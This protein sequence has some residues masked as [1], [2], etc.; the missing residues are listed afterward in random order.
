MKDKWDKRGYL[1]NIHPIEGEGQTGFKFRIY[2]PDPETGEMRQVTRQ[3]GHWTYDDAEKEYLMMEYMGANYFRKEKKK[4]RLTPTRRD[5]EGQKLRTLDDVFQLY[6]EA[7]KGEIRASYS[8][9]MRINYN[10]HIKKSFQYLYMQ[11]INQIVVNNWKHELNDKN[12]KNSASRKLKIHTKN[13]IIAI[14]RS[15]WSFALE[16][17]YTTTPLNITRIKERK[18]KDEI[19]VR[20]YWDS[21]DWYKFIESIPPEKGRE[22]ALFILC[23]ATGGRISEIRCSKEASFNFRTNEITIENNLI[24]RKLEPGMKTYEIGDTKGKDTRVIKL[25]K[26]V[27]ENINNLIKIRKEEVGKSYRA[28]ETFLFSINGKDPISPTSAQRRFNEY[29]KIAVEKYPELNPFVSIHGLRHSVGTFVAT[30]IGV[31]DARDLLGHA[32]LATTSGYVHK[33]NNLKTAIKIGS[34]LVKKVKNK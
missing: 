30:Y 8:D 9:T 28:N 16:R 31:V 29:K 27:I 15:L 17:G 10:A 22:R 14:M 3:S 1:K 23:F 7:K 18:T 2:L 25:D 5:D 21:E 6:L 11:A 4:E 32:D 34:K 13:Q 12:V 24:R 19:K 26:Y 33:S 20:A